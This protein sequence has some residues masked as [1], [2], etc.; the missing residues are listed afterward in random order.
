MP[1]AASGGGGR[2]RKGAK[3]PVL[4]KRGERRQGNNKEEGTEGTKDER[5]GS[6]EFFVR[7][8]RF[9]FENT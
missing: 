3:L 7:I 6:G 1:L 4:E 2:R 8:I 5:E 9:L